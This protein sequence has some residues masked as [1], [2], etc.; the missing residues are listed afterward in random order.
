MVKGAAQEESETP[1]GVVRSFGV[2]A[3]FLSEGD[4][5]L[6]A[7]TYA[8]EAFAALSDLERSGFPLTTVGEAVERIYHPTENQP[9]SNFKR[10]WVK[11]GEGP[12]FLTGKQLTF[13]R[14]DRE[15]FISE[16]V[17]K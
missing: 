2:A 8:A 3:H 13:F 1:L 10:I 15:K 14:P 9:R 17:K 4:S 7:T 16:R 12:P 5:R 6:D 11:A